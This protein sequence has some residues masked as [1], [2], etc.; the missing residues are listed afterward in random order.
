ME[1]DLAAKSERLVALDTALNLDATPKE[2]ENAPEAEAI[3]DGTEY[4]IEGIE[5]FPD[6]SFS[7]NEKSENEVTKAEIEP[8]PEAT[9][10]KS[11]GFNERIVFCT[12][13]DTD[14]N[15]PTVEIEL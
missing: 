7:E 6:D 8:N 1:A 5:D 13:P 11:A 12:I 3:P 10:V 2:P 15:Q 14:W 9:P 4:D